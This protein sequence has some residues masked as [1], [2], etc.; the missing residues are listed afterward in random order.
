LETH[1]ITTNTIQYT[2]KGRGYK[3]YLNTVRDALYDIGHEFVGLRD[4][5]ARK[6]GSIVVV[7]SKLTHHKQRLRKEFL[8]CCK[9]KKGS[10]VISFTRNL[11]I[12]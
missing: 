4:A 1:F 12:F 8:A 10:I 11:P 3:P 5:H 9:R 2:A 6:E 7:A